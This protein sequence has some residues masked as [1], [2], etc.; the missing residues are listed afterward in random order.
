MIWDVSWMI[1]YPL[2]FLGYVCFIVRLIAIYFSLHT[3]DYILMLYLSNNPMLPFS[4]TI[5]SRH[6]IL[7]TRASKWVDIIT[8]TP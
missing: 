6:G 7:L 5:Y 3:F 2:I 4:A 8:V 1:D